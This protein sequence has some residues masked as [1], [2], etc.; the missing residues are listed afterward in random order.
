METRDFISGGMMGDFIHQL[1]AC[2]N[3]CM[4]DGVMAN[5]YI[6]DGHDGDVWRYGIQKAY[7]DL[8]PLLKH[9]FYI[10]KFEILVDKNLLDPYCYNLNEW[11]KVVATTHAE[12]GK[13]DTCWTDLMAKIYNYEHMLGTYTFQNWIESP[14][15][16]STKG[17]IVIHRSVRHHNAPLDFWHK[18][19]CNNPNKKFVFV[20][21]NV[22]EYNDFEYKSR[23][24]AICV[25]DIAQLAEL[26]AG[27]KLFI[28]NQSAPFAL[29]CALDVPRLCELDPDPAP[30]YMGEE[31]YSS[32]MNWVLTEDKKHITKTC[33]A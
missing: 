14:T 3:I 1:Q 31:K 6:C 19:F 7:E 26:I 15:S 2:K 13:Y 23:C 16:Y 32:N 29:A 18:V 22:A 12:T 28:G 9:Q 33:W 10:N 24:S 17:A 5:L 25:K 30:F 20:T 27:C 4:R 21:T 8:L 11:R